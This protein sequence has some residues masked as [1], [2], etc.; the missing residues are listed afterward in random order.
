[1]KYVSTGNRERR[2]GNNV[3][4]LPEQAP[5]GN[6]TRVKLHSSSHCVRQIQNNCIP[7]ILFIP[8]GTLT[9]DN[10]GVLYRSTRTDIRES[11]KTCHHLPVLN[12]TSWSAVRTGASETW[13]AGV[14]STVWTAWLNKLFL[15]NLSLERTLGEWQTASDGAKTN[16]KLW[17]AN[18]KRPENTVTVTHRWRWS[19]GQETQI[20]LAKGLAGYYLS[21]RVCSVCV[22]VKGWRE[23]CK[24]CCPK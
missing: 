13:A 10:N 17:S 20:Y 5:V 15:L 7:Q 2:H 1:M 3:K 11:F 14:F 9:R 22:W 12:Y 24:K 4:C 18:I 19:W 21:S 6:N 8:R 16:D 23:I